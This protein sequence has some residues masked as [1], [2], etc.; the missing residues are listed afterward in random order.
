M[1]QYTSTPT[2]APQSTATSTAVQRAALIIGIT[3]LLVGIAGF[4]PGI[5]QNFDEIEFAGHESGAELLGIFQVSVL[6]NLVH[7]AFGVIGLIAARRAKS[8][9]AFLIGGGVVYLVLLGYGLL[10]DQDHDANFVPFNDADNWLHLGLGVAMIGLGVILGRSA[11]PD[12]E[13]TH[14]PSR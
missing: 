10:V 14:V 11:M 8:S 3:F 9:S 5:T 6:H 13:L 12:D 4:I 2:T 7:M 1:S